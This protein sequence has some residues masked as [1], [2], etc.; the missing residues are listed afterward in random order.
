MLKKLGVAAVSAVMILLTLLTA[1]CNKDEIRTEITESSERPV[2]TVADNE[3]NT[4]DA[5]KI[6]ETRFLNM[7]NHNYVYDDDYK[8]IEDMVNASMPALLELREEDSSFIKEEYVGE[9]IYNMYGIEIEDYSVLN[10][11]FPKSEGYVY[12]LPRGYEKYKHKPILL[13][14]NEDGS[15]TL[16]TQVTADTHDG[17]EIIGICETLFVENSQSVFGFNIINSDF[18]SNGNSL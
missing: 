1:F 13:S 10:E 7:L 8:S 2:I 4:P 15:Y 16:K 3:K 12:I 5:L 6:L 9:F 11:D 14:E 17:Q 18:V